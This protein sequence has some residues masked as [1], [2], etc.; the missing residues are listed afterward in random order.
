M[1]VIVV[2]ERRGHE[3]GEHNS[4]RQLLTTMRSTEKPHPTESNQASRDS[5]MRRVH[6]RVSR[7]LAPP[8]E[9]YQVQNRGK[10]D[11][12]K[13]PEWARPID[14]DMFEGCGHEG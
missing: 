1:G 4:P 7:G 9:I 10:V 5:L 6:E 11:W 8:R 13:V 3:P 12:S 2:N 14:P